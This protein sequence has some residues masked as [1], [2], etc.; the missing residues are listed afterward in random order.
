NVVDNF[1]IKAGAQF[2][3]SDFQIRGQN[4]I[5]SQVAVRALP[6]GTTLASIT[7][8]ITD[9]GNLLGS[10]PA[11]FAAIDPNKWRQAVGFDSFQYCGVECGAARSGVREQI[12]SGYL[13][14]TF[15]TEGVLP[16]TVRGDAGVRY[17]HTKQDSFGF[18][19]VAAPAGAQYPTVGKRGD[20]N[21]SYEDWLPSMNLV[22]EITPK[23][24]ARFSAAAVMS[25]PELGQLTPV[26]GV[27]VAT[28][29]G[30]VN[31]PFLDPI[32][33]NTFD[34]ALEWYFA[35]GSLLSVAY[36]HKNIET[37][38]QS[39]SEQVPYSSLGLPDALLD[40]TPSTPADIFTVNRSNN[41]PGGK[42]NGVEVN[43]QAQLSFL[44]G[45]L[46]NFGVLGSYTYV[47]SKITYILSPIQT[48]VDDQLQILGEVVR[49]RGIDEQRRGV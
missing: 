15:N 10:G 42:L 25:R 34:A 13:M 12:T 47:T 45:F 18:I 26:S 17:V 29:T 9:F 32:R 4:L 48:T 3:E 39:I 7:R 5:P 22:F 24:Q 37:Y 2:R 21:R 31:N 36:F 35:P 30:T 43:A 6:A 20:V 16:F 19:P 23:L 38:I 44:P 33:A 28:R 8:Q 49:G 11:E 40:G 41:T 27:T 1:A 14:T 46:S